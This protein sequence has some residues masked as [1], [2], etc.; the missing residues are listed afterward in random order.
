MMPDLGIGIHILLCIYFYIRETLKRRSVPKELQSNQ[1]EK[2]DKCRADAT[3]WKM[4]LHS[5]AGNEYMMSYVLNLRLNAG[6]DGHN[7]TNDGN[8][9][10]REKQQH[11][12]RI[13][14]SPSASIMKW[15]PHSSLLIK[16]RVVPVNFFPPV[17]I[18]R[19]FTQKKTGFP[20]L[21]S[22]ANFQLLVAVFHAATAVYQKCRAAMR[23]RLKLRLL[24]WKFEN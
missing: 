6:I 5:T 21:C 19:I 15:Q 7:V 1:T 8:C 3:E 20:V 17:S 22:D 10:R 24:W 12:M 11:G 18:Y 9:S 2:N 14:Q 16:T 13:H 4:H 23:L